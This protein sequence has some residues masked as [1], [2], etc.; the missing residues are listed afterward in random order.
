[1]PVQP[2]I[3]KQ[4]SDLPHQTFHRCEVDEFAFYFFH[5]PSFL[6]LHVS[7]RTV[8]N[9]IRILEVNQAVKNAQLR[10]LL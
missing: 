7:S 6:K 4:V 9:G 5:P 3:F 10:S 1:M 8:K 2:L